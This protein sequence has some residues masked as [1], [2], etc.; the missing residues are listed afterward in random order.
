MSEQDSHD[1]T[2]EEDQAEDL[3]L[4]GED[5]LIAR[6]MAIRPYAL[7]IILFAAGILILKAT[8]FD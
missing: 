5:D 8:L 3:K 6:R 7:G 4:V 2:L 1:L